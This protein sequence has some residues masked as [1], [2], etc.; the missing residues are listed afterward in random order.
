[1]FKGPLES[2][3]KNLRRIRL[4]LARMT[5]TKENL[6]DV[7]NR[8]WSMSS[9]SVRSQKPPPKK[10]RK[11]T[12]D[13]VD[14]MIFQSFIVTEWYSRASCGVFNSDSQKI[15]FCI[16]VV[17]SLQPLKLY[18]CCCLLLIWRTITST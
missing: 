7:F 6:T 13:Y 4:N 12:F 15:E 18:H 3:H 11:F 1:M 16:R 8:L 9:P 17:S 5:N 10:R 14:D 2:Q